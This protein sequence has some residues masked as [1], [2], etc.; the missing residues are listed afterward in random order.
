MRNFDRKFGAEFLE[1][2]PG[3]PGVYLVY[4]QQDELIYVGKAKHLKRRLSQYRNALRRKKHRRMRAIVKEAARI[5]IQCAEAD[6][7][8]C[9]TEA[10]LIQKH[11]PRWNIVGA[12]SFLYPVIGIRTTN[13]DIEFCMTTI[14]QAVLKECPGFEFHGAFRSRRITG[15]AFFALMR[16]LKFVGHVN[17]L[18]HR[19]RIPRHSYIFSFRRLP[20]N[21][22]GIWAS[23]YKGES[24]L[25]ME[26]LILNL[27]GNTGARSRPDKIQEHLD[28]LKRFWRHE[29]LT[30]AKARE[31]TGYTEWPV[32]QY[33]RDLLFICYKAG[34]TSIDGRFGERNA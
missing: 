19:G 9:L 17:V 12:Y 7:D 23:F 22:A 16:L 6:L 8:A 32:P 10:M 33:H 5:E 29:V 18:N 13:R 24:A 27:T 31:A 11:R 20:S 30:L 28:E 15:D 1:S 3:A 34:V 14:P 21:W 25:A 26:E 2:L 4:D